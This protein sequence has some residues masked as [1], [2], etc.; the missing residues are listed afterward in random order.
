MRLLRPL[1]TRTLLAIAVSLV[2]AGLSMTSVSAG[3]DVPASSDGAA[4]V[5]YQ[6]SMNVFRRFEADTEAMYAF[7]NCFAETTWSRPATAS[8]A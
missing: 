3:N 5:M 6:P 2:A 1:L 7:T 8:T 4:A